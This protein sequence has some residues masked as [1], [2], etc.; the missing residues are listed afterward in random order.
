[1]FVPIFHVIGL[2]VEIPCLAIARKYHP[3]S[4]VYNTCENSN[5]GLLL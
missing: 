1:V 5:F 3:Y 4:T 2:S